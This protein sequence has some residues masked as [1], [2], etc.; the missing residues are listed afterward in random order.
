M[1]GGH[2]KYGDNGHL[3]YSASGH[4]VNECGCQSCA[5]LMASGCADANPVYLTI[6][7]FTG[8]H[9]DC[10][11]GIWELTDDY[12]VKWWGWM[13]GNSSP[14]DTCDCGD[15]GEIP[16]DVYIDCE[17]N[18]ENGCACFKIFAD[19]PCLGPPPGLVWRVGGS[20]ECW[21]NYNCS[22]GAP[23]GSGTLSGLYDC[24]GQTGSFSIS[25]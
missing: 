15:C 7:G 18:D 11:N 14:L 23:E 21:Q 24:A 4:L 5:E 6:S 13:G 8:D 3:L 17:S 20:V 16:L 19:I 12:S 25:V 1:A 9:V 2:L 10:L 22:N